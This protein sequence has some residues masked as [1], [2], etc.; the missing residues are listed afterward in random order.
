M[1]DKP[2]GMP[3]SMVESQMANSAKHPRAKLWELQ[4]WLSQCWCAVCLGVWLC[5]LPVLLRVYTLPALLQRLTPAGRQQARSRALEMDQAVR[6]V[7]WVCH[8]RPFRGPLFPRVCLRQALALYY[9]LTRLGYPAEIYF[10]VYKDKK[11]FHGHSWVTVQG[12]PIAERTPPEVFRVVYS[13]P[14]ASYHA[15]RDVGGPFSREGSFVCPRG[16]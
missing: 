15:P 2:G 4:A 6:V 13:Y 8:L 7:M 14:A 9:V 11:E 16:A 3:D 1:P 12:K 10:G 5:R